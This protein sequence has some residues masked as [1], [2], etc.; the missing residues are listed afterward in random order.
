M[1]QRDASGQNGR[2]LPVGLK[3][4]RDPAAGDYEYSLCVRAGILGFTF[5]RGAEYGADQYILPRVDNGFAYKCIR[6]G[7][8]SAEPT[9]PTAIGAAVRSGAASFRCVGAG[10]LIKGASP[11]EA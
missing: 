3:I 5:V 2:W 9:W 1:T 8:T 11:I 4:D 10:A 7:V 6:G